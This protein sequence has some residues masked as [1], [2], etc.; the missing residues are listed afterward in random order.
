LAEC[1][2]LLR[3]ARKLERWD[4]I[5]SFN[6]VFGRFRKLR[7]RDITND[8]SAIKDFEREIVEFK[9][10]IEAEK[11]RRE[12]LKKENKA[13]L[14]GC[15][16]LLSEAR[17]LKKFKG[18]RD[19][20]RAIVQFEKFKSINTNSDGVAI[21]KFKRKIAEFREKMDA[22]KKRRAGLEAKKREL[23]EEAKKL[24]NKAGR[25]GSE[26]RIK[27]FAKLVKR[28]ENLKIEYIEGADVKIEDFSR[29]TNEFNVQV[30]GKEKERIS[31]MDDEEIYRMIEGMNRNW[32]EGV[33]EIVKQLKETQS[34]MGT[35]IEKKETATATAAQEQLHELQSRLKTYMNRLPTSWLKDDE[36]I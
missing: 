12:E 15:K 25:V 1:K 9:A 34:K 4:G 23:L 24:L 19:F 30:R 36:V 20:D 11:K 32:L 31:R 17:K 35:A 14:A 26:V 5:R 7:I 6:E 10:K 33:G 21:E 2:G 18:I 8:S 13:L 27:T 22:E 29:A 28:F 16:G 3:E